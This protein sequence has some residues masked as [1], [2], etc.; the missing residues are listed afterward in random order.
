MKKHKFISVLTLVLIILLTAFLGIA[1]GEPNVVKVQVHIVNGSGLT[2]SQVRNA[3]AKANM[4]DAN[5]ARFVVDSNHYYSDPNATAADANKNEPNK[6]N[7]WAVPKCTVTG[8][9]NNV[10]GQQGSIIELVDPNA[11]K[12]P[13]DP[14][15][16]KVFMKDSTLAHELNHALGLDHNK[17]DGT[18]ITDP[19]N[20][21]Y[22][23]N[24]THGGTEPR[25]SCHR[26][27]IKLEPWQRQKIAQSKMLKAKDA[28]ERGY[29]G[30]IYDSVG[31]VIS[32]YIDLNWSQ[33][34][35]QWVANTCMFY[36]T[37][38]VRVLSF[39]AYSEIGFYIESDNNFSTG[40]PPEGLDYYVALQPADNQISLWMFE[41][42][43]GWVSLDPNGIT[44]ELTYTSKDADVPPVPSGVRFELPLSMLERRAGDVISYKAFAREG[45]QM[46]VSPDTGLFGVALPPW[47]PD[48]VRDGVINYN[49]L[50]VLAG[51]WLLSPPNDP[52]VDLYYDGRINFRDFAEFGQYWDQRQP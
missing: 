6:I 20:K 46:D 45:L 25:H 13:C 5:A 14:N 2:E 8:E 16:S 22:P 33:G 24:S 52:N 39:A 18:P 19:E 44:Y 10:S 37:A 41:M 23:D 40:Q 30:D 17:P 48:F 49:D 38:Q 3:L 34:W 35:S 29:G 28:V 1:N 43:Y 47:P 32:E 27:G 50:D 9:P 12:D 31:D 7:I 36:V 15:S 26:T 21:M 51:N 4:A 11:T 42:G